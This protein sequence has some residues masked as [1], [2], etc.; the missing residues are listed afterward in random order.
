MRT[1]ICPF[2]GPSLRSFSNIHAPKKK[3]GPNTKAGVCLVVFPPTMVNFFFP[4]PFQFREEIFE[5]RKKI[6]AFR[7]K[8]SDEQFGILMP[9]TEKRCALRT[10]RD[11]FGL[12]LV[13]S[14]RKI[15]FGKKLGFSLG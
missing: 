2:E 15:V 1:Y 10:S 14:F 13:K 4:K 11:M 5:F 6:L 9:T 12:F 3:T 7:E 8:N